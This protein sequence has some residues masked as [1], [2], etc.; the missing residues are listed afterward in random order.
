[1]S[2]FLIQHHSVSFLTVKPDTDSKRSELVLEQSAAVSRGA[3]APRSA[4][5]LEVEDRRIGQAIRERFPRRAAVGGMPDAHVGTD[6]NIL[7]RNRVHDDRIVLHVEQARRR[8]RRPATRRPTLAVETPDVPKIA[9][10]ESTTPRVSPT[11][12]RGTA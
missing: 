2:F 1:M 8:S 7:R 3:Q 4:V 10:A 5:H 6:V 12:R 9:H 11:Q